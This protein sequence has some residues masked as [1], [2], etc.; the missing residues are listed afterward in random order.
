MRI[1]IVW[2][3]LTCFPVRAMDFGAPQKVLHLKNHLRAN[4]I[5]RITK[6]I[7]NAFW[8]LK[9]YIRFISKRLSKNSFE[10]NVKNILR[11]CQIDVIFTS[12]YFNIYWQKAYFSSLLSS[13]RKYEHYTVRVNCSFYSMTDWILLDFGGNDINV[14]TAAGLIRL[15]IS[16][17][18]IS[19]VCN[20]GAN[21]IPS[22]RF[23]GSLVPTWST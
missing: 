23:N 8:K 12:K 14:C 2:T 18:S 5:I 9:M 3:C 21:L 15:H 20:E 22:V 19:L 7:N 16:P 17:V 1:S 13:K 6:S 11:P 10:I 4:N